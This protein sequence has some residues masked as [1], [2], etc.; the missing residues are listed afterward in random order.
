[1]IFFTQPVV[2]I[3]SRTIFRFTLIFCCFLIFNKSFSQ[4]DEANDRP[5]LSV[6]MSA[7]APEKIT[8]QQY[9][10]LD[11]IPL[12]SIPEADK[13]AVL[14]FGVR[15]GFSQFGMHGS[16]VDYR[17][18]MGARVEQRIGYD[19]GLELR[20][21]IYR[22]LHGSLGV[23]YTQRSASLDGGYA[24]T[25]GPITMSYI[26]V[27]FATGASL[28][29]TKAISVT[30][31]VG[32]AFNYRVSEQ[33]PYDQDVPAQGKVSDYRMTASTFY[34]LE[35]STDA[36]KKVN[37]FISYRKIGDL[38]P[39]HSRSDYMARRD[40][41]YIARGNT[42]SIGVRFKRQHRTREARVATGKI[43]EDAP[44]APFQWGVKAGINLNN[45]LYD[46]LPYGK[47]DDSRNA[48]G[49]NVGLFAR[50][51]L[52][53]RWAFVPELQYITKGYSYNTV[54]GKNTITL[55]YVEQPFLL[56]YSPS[57]KISFEA[58]PVVGMFLDASLNGPRADSRVTW[59]AEY[60]EFGLTGGARYNLSPLFSVGARYFHGLKTIAD[61]YYNSNIFTGN[62]TREYNTNVQLSAF[63]KF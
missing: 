1:M 39:F 26:T 20:L 32:F 49:V 19:A 52:S 22:Y 61:I 14:S 62:S 24:P 21:D 28:L 55:H 29:R 43:K 54:D 30:A 60:L 45:T 8:P 50:I 12:Y 59:Y 53:N 51:R 40:D 63:M 4:T 27:P 41:E 48:L 5:V 38:G 10:L 9:P 34:G 7:L 16:G 2:A 17:E 25:Y 33:N 44:V 57:R 3:G 6:G 58:G 35:V 18:S 46:V 42:F 56:A 13:R 31:E 37:I 47:T 15:Q 23:G 36:I 11:T